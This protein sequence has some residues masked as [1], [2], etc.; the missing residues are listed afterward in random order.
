MLLRFGKMHCL[1][2][3]LM[4]VELLGQYAQIDAGL[5][6][7]WASRVHG[8]GFRRLVLVGI[9]QHPDADF[10]CRSFDRQGHELDSRFTDLCCAA[11]MLHDRRL[12]NQP[13]L[14]M[15]TRNGC[16]PVHVREDGWVAVRYAQELW[17]QPQAGVELP[18][19]VQGFLQ[20]LMQRHGLA[21]EWMLA[22]QQLVLWSRQAPPQRLAR[23][24]QPVS[25]RL[26][27]WQVFWLHAE[28]EAV[29]VQFWQSDA[30]SAGHDP[31]LLAVSGLQGRISRPVVQVGWQQE[32]LLVDFLPGQD[33]IQLFARAHRVYEGQIRL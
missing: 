19:A 16:L 3:D 2:D 25:G 8:V 23:L 31:C 14:R 20:E 27:G 32:H 13:E 1:G 30:E 10:D 4:L 21:L 5:I 12:S 11:R 26:R 15:Q 33:A 7:E 18:A 9:P 24:L 29:R 22:G 17:P 6:R 28:E